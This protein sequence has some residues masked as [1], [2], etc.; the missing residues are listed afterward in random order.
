MLKYG[1]M[2]R[3]K[4]DMKIG[5]YK[6]SGTHWGHD[7]YKGL[8]WMAMPDAYRG[9]NLSMNE[10][11]NKADVNNFGRRTEL[12]EEQMALSGIGNEIGSFN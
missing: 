3:K 6:S 7:F 2:D 12:R 1:K 8:L 5:D 10:Y 9:V 11:I 4:S